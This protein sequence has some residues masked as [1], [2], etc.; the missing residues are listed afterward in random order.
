[1]ERADARQHLVQD[2]AE[3]E[4]VRPLV[5]RL[6]LDLLGR[7]VAER[8][9]HDAGL[10]ARARGRKIRLRRRR[11]F[12]LRQLRQ[13]EVENLDSPVVNQEQV[14]GLQVPVNDPLLVR[15]R[16]ATRDLCGEVDRF[17]HGHRATREPRPQRLPLEQLRHDEGRSLVRPEIVHRHDVRVVQGARRLSFL[18]EAAQAI[19]I[20]RIRGGQ[21]LDR[22]LAPQAIVPRP[23][24]LP[25]S[26]GAER[27][28]DFVG[29]EARTCRECYRRTAPAILCRAEI[30][31]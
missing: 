3:R 8:S 26:A 7:H 27:R 29:T 2:R 20:G 13:T 4:D 30:A 22:D 6:A 1:M 14:F 15:R 11:P 23:V 5:R 10:R 16:E 18:L 9:H 21:D 28:Q 25:H 31:A 12:G 24:D 19:A 17:A